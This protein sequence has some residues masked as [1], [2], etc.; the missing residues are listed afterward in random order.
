PRRSPRVAS[1]PRAAPPPRP[2]PRCTEGRT[3][4]LRTSRTRYPQGRASPPPVGAA[5]C[6]TR[7]AGCP[8]PRGHASLLPL[9]QS[10]PRRQRDLVLDYPA[11]VR[12]LG[13]PRETELVPVDRG[14]K[15][16]P[17][18]VVAVRIGDRTGNRAAKLDRKGD[19]LQ[20]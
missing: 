17:Q 8:R 10:E 20:R 11:A 18:A 6:T 19:A 4:A 14:L 7:R 15:V 16:D 12:Q 3:R 2:G 5:C 13:V 1:R 9:H